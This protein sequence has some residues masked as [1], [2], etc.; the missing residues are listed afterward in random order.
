MDNSTIIRLSSNNNKIFEVPYTIV[1]QSVTLKNMFDDIGNASPDS[2]IPLSTITEPI[3][4]K[5]I[6]YCDHHQNDVPTTKL[7]D[8]ENID[9]WDAEFIGNPPNQSLLFDL[10][11][12][13]NFLDIKSLLDLACKTVANLIKGKTVEEIR[14]IFGITNDFTPE[15]EEQI[16]KENEWCDEK[17]N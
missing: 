10:I 6:Q 11:L 1:K 12:V 9:A 13:A 8:A 2:V 15:E 14:C 7:Q 4:E 17:L 5:V 3:L 16:R